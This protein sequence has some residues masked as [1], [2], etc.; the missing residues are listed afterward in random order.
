MCLK[1]RVFYSKQILK[2]THGFSFSY[3][4]I[5]EMQTMQNQKSYFSAPKGKK[6]HNPSV[7]GVP[8]Y[9]GVLLIWR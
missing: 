7:N 1:I 5:S 2:S 8:A 3:S 9:V 6:A 4:T